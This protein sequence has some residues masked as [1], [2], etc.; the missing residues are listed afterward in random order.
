MLYRAVIEIK[1]NGITRLSPDELFDLRCDLL[2][3]L[4]DNPHIDDA[5]TPRLYCADSGI[6]G[7]ETLLK[8]ILGQYA[9]RLLAFTVL[10]PLRHL[11]KE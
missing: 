1:T 4:D 9:D 6:T 8:D 10:D 2:G 11:F 3:G 5:F 7:Y